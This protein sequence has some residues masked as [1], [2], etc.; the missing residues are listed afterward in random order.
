MDI[1]LEIGAR[2]SD[3]AD[4]AGAVVAFLRFGDFSLDFELRFHLADLLTGNAVRNDLR[5]SIIE[6][7]RAEGIE[8][9][10]PQR[11]LNIR[12]TDTY[13]PLEEALEEEGDPARTRSPHPRGRRTAPARCPEPAG[14][15]GAGSGDDEL[16]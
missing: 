3:G 5:L 4:D 13:G 1:L 11:N 16:G 12:F 8:I 10:F 6:R 7:F 9:P 14:R 2:P 15:S